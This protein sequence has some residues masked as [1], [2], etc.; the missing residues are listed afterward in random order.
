MAKILCVWE[1][2][3]GMGHASI[4]MPVVKALKEKGH[5]ISMAFRDIVVTKPLY[6][7]TG[8]PVRQAPFLKLRNKLSSTTYNLAD[9]FCY[10]GLS[11]VNGLMGLSDV[12]TKILADEKPDLILA[13]FSPTLT[14]LTIG[15]IPTITIGSGFTVPPGGKRLPSIRFWEKEIREDSAKNEDVVTENIN[16]V[17]HNF[18]LLPLDYF[19]DLFRGEGTFVCTFPEIDVYKENR[20]HPAIG[21]LTNKPPTAI[22]HP[23][24]KE[25]KAFA[26]LN[27]RDKHIEKI[28]TGILDSEI[29]CEAFI[30]SFPK[31]LHK[32]YSR[33]NL[34]IHKEPQPMPEVLD[35][36]AFV[37][38]HGGI[39]TM[40][41]CLL[42]GVPQLVLARHL[43]QRVNGS[44]VAAELNLGIIMTAKYFQDSEIVSENMKKMALT[45]QYGIA[46]NKL[47]NDLGKRY[48]E[49]LPIDQIIESCYEHL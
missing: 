37:I 22:V 40:E 6:E 12:W 46:S 20:N 4:I 26:Y 3:S 1:Y 17:R 15:R 13:E 27:A 16:Q 24:K 21:S 47:A 29:P 25:C 45:P 43:E 7:G 33:K 30:R 5:D 23:S 14:M 44:R 48:S 42:Y 11:E 34:L 31:E 19:S 10:S 39:S 9:I 49:Q 36:V 32:E 38:H 18:G 41:N 8:I 2:G 28:L 35:R